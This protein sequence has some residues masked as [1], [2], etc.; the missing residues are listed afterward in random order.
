VAKW[1]SAAKDSEGRKATFYAVAGD[2]Y[3]GTRVE[4][5]HTCFGC[6]TGHTFIPANIRERTN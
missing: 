5:Y 4:G 6:H 3:S 1:S 2:H